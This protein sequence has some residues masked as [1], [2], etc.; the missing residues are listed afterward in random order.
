MLQ[1]F[2][3]HFPELSLTNDLSLVLIRQS[4]SK[5]FLDLKAWVPN[6][7]HEVNGEVLSFHELSNS[8]ILAQLDQLVLSIVKGYLHNLVFEQSEDPDSELDQEQWPLN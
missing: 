8:D 5:K 4:Q 2:P 7:V 6:Q 1:Q 3:D